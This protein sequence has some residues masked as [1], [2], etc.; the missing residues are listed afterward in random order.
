MAVSQPQRLGLP[1]GSRVYMLRATRLVPLIPA[2]QLPYQVR[3]IPRELTHREMSDGNWKFSHETGSTATILEVQAPGSIALPHSAAPNNTVLRQTPAPF[4]SRFLAPDHHVRSESCSVRSDAPEASTVHLLPSSAEQV[5]GHTPL[6]VTAT[7]DRSISLADTFSSIYPEDAQRFRYRIPTPSGLEPDQSKKE[8]CTYWIKCGDCAY[9]SYNC[10]F[11][12]D[13]PSRVKLRELGFRDFPQW[14]KDKSAIG[15]RAP[16]W[17]EQRLARRDTNGDDPEDVQ[18]PRA[19]PDPSTFRS[20][21]R[22]DDQDKGYG[23]LAS[24]QSKNVQSTPPPVPTPEV[25]SRR[26]GQISNLLIDLDEDPAP[27]PSPQLFKRSSSIVSSSCT[28]VTSASPSKSS[29]FSPVVER[30]VTTISNTVA[31]P[32]NTVNKAMEGQQA[33]TPVASPEPHASW[34]I[35][36]EAD[37]T[38]VKQASSNDL[39]PPERSVR[40][41]KKSAKH[42]GLA[43]SKHAAASQRKPTIIQP[44]VKDYRRKLPQPEEKLIPTGPEADLAQGRRAFPRKGRGNKSTNGA[45]KS[46]HSAVKD[47]FG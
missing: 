39:T 24:F 29:L 30:L 19:F 35:E 4:K 10:K 26:D 21:Q 18:P 15:T 1:E 28:T 34:D 13:M 40:W 20:K 27:P 41:S 16:T 43:A 23:S 3:G 47:T 38:P 45:Q 31:Q 44:Q 2:D 11:K 32:E 25:T 5:S 12:H 17:M 42:Y 9:T 22:D 37:A 6:V 36:I 33:A 14:W 8:Y 7:P 46:T